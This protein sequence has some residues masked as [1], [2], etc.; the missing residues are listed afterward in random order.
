MSLKRLP[1]TIFA[2]LPAGLIYLSLV[3][4]PAFAQD[5]VFGRV[6]LPEPIRTGY[7]TFD[8]ANN[9]GGGIIGFASNLIKLI[10]IIG[11]LWAFIN[12]ILAGFTY[13]TSQGNPEKIT[14][15]NQQMYNSLIGLT[16]MVGSFVLAAITG[17]L[18]FGDASAILIPKI[19]GPGI[20]GTPAR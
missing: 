8:A 14:Q 6:D 1:T 7:G 13:I 2:A 3:V 11:G 12:L 19:Y 17:W 9:P 4:S 5:D 20:N 10:M 18:L 15:A 16:I